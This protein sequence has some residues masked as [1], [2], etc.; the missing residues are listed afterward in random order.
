MRLL[1]V[2]FFDKALEVKVSSLTKVEPKFQS[3]NQDFS[4][5][6]FLLLN[7]STHMIF[8]DGGLLAVLRVVPLLKVLVITCVFFLCSFSLVNHLHFVKPQLRSYSRSLRRRLSL[9]GA[10]RDLKFRLKLGRLQRRSS[11]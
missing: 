7:V 10:R 11:L 6:I 4:V 2:T 1:L 8:L 3:C 9:P 5:F